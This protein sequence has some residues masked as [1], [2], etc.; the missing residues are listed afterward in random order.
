MITTREIEINDRKFTVTQLPGFASLRLFTKLVKLI[1]PGL[2]GL[3]SA[4]GGNLNADMGS[5]L[6]ALGQG[7]ADSIF[8]KITPDGMEDLTKTLLNSAT[9]EL[10]GKSAPVLRVF[11][12]IFQGRITDLLALLKFALGVNFEGFF[13]AKSGVTAEV[14][15]KS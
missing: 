11:D 1:G 3:L 8:E 14:P 7:G 4:S 9:V 13:S 10:D 6:A 5:I 12:T 15:G 2:L